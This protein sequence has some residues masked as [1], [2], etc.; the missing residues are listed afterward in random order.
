MERR[1]FMM[2]NSCSGVG[3][4]AGEKDEL[5]GGVDRGC[6]AASSCAGGLPEDGGASWHWCVGLY[7]DDRDLNRAEHTLHTATAD[8]LIAVRMDAAVC[9]LVVLMKV[10]RCSSNSAR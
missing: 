2:L 9:F 6:A 7:H 4:L 10:R 1:A 8:E 5:Q 3:R